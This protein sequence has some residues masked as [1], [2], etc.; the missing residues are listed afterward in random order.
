MTRWLNPV[1]LG[2]VAVAYGLWFGLRVLLWPWLWLYGRYRP[3]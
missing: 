3:T 1:L 2:L